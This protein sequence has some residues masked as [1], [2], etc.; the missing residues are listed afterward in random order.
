MARTFVPINVD[1]RL[2][3][4]KT[5][6]NLKK[7]KADKVYLAFA[8]RI[9]FTRCEERTQKNKLLMQMSERLI[10]EGFKTAVWIGTC[11]FGGEFPE[12]NA[13]VGKT[14][15]QRTSISGR[16]IGDSFCPYDEKF[17][18]L[19][20][21][22][23]TELAETGIEEIM[24]DDELV[25]SV[26]PGI[27]CACD[28]HM[29]EYSRRLGEHISRS[30]IGEKAF[31][32]GRNKYRDVWLDLM[33]ETLNNYCKRLREAVDKVNPN[34]RMGFCAGFT[35]W[36]FEGIDAIELTKTLAGG[37][38][39]FLRFTGAPYW[40]AYKR[41]GLQSLQNIIE[42]VRQQ[43]SWAK[44]SGTD[45]FTE[46]DTYPHSRFQCPAAYAELFDLATRVSDDMDALKYVMGYYA[47]PEYEM[48]YINR[49]ERNLKLYDEI[50]EVFGGKNAVGIRI[51]EEMRTIRDAE[52]P[53]T[54]AGENQIMERWFAQASIIPSSVAIPTTYEGDGIFGMAF[55]ENGKYLPEKAFG[56]GLVLD[57][58]AA[59]ILQKKGIDTGLLNI[60][61][62]I[63]RAVE[64]F[65][66]YG[67][68]TY[69]GNSIGYEIEINEKA[70]VLS[71]FV[72]GNKKSPSVYLYENEAGQRF[73]VYGFKI[74]EM[75]CQSGA[76]LSYCRGKQLNDWAKWLGGE[77]FPVVC[78]GHPKLYCICK[79]DDS[80]TAAAYFNCHPDEIE[81]A[82]I[83]AKHPVE[84]VRFINCTGKTEGNKIIIDGIKAY[85]F[86]GVEFDK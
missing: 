55:G 73:M 32:G 27:G 68:S 31:T 58:K 5:I 24:L 64:N 37:T 69:I 1:E 76:L 81:K 48:G 78:N 77:D 52:L 71:E 28:H 86:C 62:K 7:M 47:H 2:D 75:W 36:D 65:D 4:E 57:L 11:G 54:F 41:F 85:G 14:L 63:I 17:T 45:L 26:L 3:F 16:T 49:H 59:E 84:N 8:D 72:C 39:P 79:E 10:S 20:C 15:T 80:R 18:E 74:E 21:D 12:Y 66:A 51:Y 53:E 23:V 46:A 6:V 30:E 13:E 25:Q 9:Y 42:C 22:F 34:I 38:K 61:K 40:Y 33:G 83:L 56:R 60:G 67:T 35:S 43:Y 82:E 50:K 44:D 70:K 29:E 19:M